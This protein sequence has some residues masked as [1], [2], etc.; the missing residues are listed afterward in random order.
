MNGIAHGADVQYRDVWMVN[1]L[2]ELNNIKRQ[3][4]RKPKAQGEGE[5]RFVRECQVCVREYR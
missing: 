5:V 3:S 1:L 4:E 2:Q